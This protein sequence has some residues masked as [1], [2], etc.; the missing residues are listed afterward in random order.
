MTRPRLSED[1]L[2]EP[3]DDGLPVR[4]FSRLD[5]RFLFEDLYAKLAMKAA[6]ED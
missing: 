4:V 3:N 2:Y 5:V 6:G 1:G